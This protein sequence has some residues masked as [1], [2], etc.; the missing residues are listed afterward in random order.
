MYISELLNSLEMTDKISIFGFKALLRQYE[1]K[2]FF[3]GAIMPALFCILIL[4]PIFILTNTS[5]IE[6]IEL[7][8]DL[9]NSIIPSLLGFVLGGYAVLIGFSNVSIIAV[10][11]DKKITLY[12]KISTVFSMSLIMQIFLLIFSFIV[13]IILKADISINFIFANILNIICI[14]FLVFGLF[15]IILMIKDLV[16]NI[17]NLSQYQNFK[18]NK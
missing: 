4:V 6:L 2:L 11:I 15:Y 18:I 12:Q 13:K 8:V 7:I 9:I 5:L 16:I 17:F 14:I 10:K 3:K 1:F